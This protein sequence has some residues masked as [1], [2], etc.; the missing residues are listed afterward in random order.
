VAKE[1]LAGDHVGAWW[2]W[3]QVS[4]VVGQQ[5]RVLLHSVTPVESARAART[6]EGTGGVA[7]V[8][9][10]RISG[11]TGRRML[12]ARRVTIG[13]TCPVLR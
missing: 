7:A 10:A 3:H 8:S 11:S 12:A 5:S 1:P 2:T 6:E 13:W 9:A 4:G